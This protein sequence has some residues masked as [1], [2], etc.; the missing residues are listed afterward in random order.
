MVISQC[1]LCLSGVTDQLRCKTKRCMRL[2]GTL[3]G[4]ALSEMNHISYCDEETLKMTKKRNLQAD[5]MNDPMFT[6]S[7]VT[8][9]AG[10]ASVKLALEE[11]QDEDTNRTTTHQLVSQHKRETNTNNQITD[12]LGCQVPEQERQWAGQIR[13]AHGDQWNMQRQMHGCCQH[14]EGG[15]ATTSRVTWILENSRICRKLARA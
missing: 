14:C 2:I 4:E 8:D 11:L 12:K 1:V 15:P 5:V 13:S 3:Q 6:S 7:G 9:E 10:Q